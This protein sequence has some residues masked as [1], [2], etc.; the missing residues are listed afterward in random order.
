MT[1]R[2]SFLWL[3]MNFSVF[4]DRFSLRTS[5]G[6]V[7]NLFSSCWHVITSWIRSPAGRVDVHLCPPECQLLFV[8]D[9][10]SVRCL[11]QTCGSS[12]CYDSDLL[13]NVWLVSFVFP[14]CCLHAQA[15]QHALLLVTVSQ[16]GSDLSFLCQRESPII[17]LSEW[18]HSQLTVRSLSVPERST[19]T[20]WEQLVWWWRLCSGWTGFS[21]LIWSL[22]SPEGIFLQLQTSC[23]AC[24]VWSLQKHTA[25]GHMINFHQKQPQSQRDISPSA[26]QQP[27]TVWLVRPSLRRNQ[28]KK[29]RTGKM[30]ERMYKKQRSKARDE[31]DWR[32]KN[33]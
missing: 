16:R 15:S 2:Q 10:R 32:E 1:L 30:K 6:A 8:C 23:Q 22:S 12:L 33:R 11:L 4:D 21:Q 20:T 19:R 5:L 28:R 17:T 27:P 7:R 31:T 3:E 9:V 26:P 29:E 18:N 13:S 24:H 14:S 25:D